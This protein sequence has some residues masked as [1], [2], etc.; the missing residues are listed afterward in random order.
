MT[1][2]AII[3][4]FRLFRFELSFSAGACVFLG[5][6][7]ALGHLP[8]LRGALYGFMSFF[9]ISATALILNDYFDVEI[10]RINAP[11]RPIPA[12][13]VTRS[14]VLILSIVVALLGFVS[15]Y[16]ISEEAFVVVFVVWLVG[17]LYNWRLK[18]AGLWGNLVVSFSV[19]M[20]FVFGGIAAGNPFEK[21]V[22]YL[23]MTAMLIDLGEEIAA[24]A[25]D[26]EGDR[27]GGSRSLAVVRG[28]QNAMRFAA[29]VFTLVV[30]G[31]AVPFLFGWFSRVYLL[32]IALLDTV[33]VYSVPKLLSPQIADRRKYVRLIYLGGLAVIVMFIV[34]RLWMA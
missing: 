24:D 19:G 10:D 6:L 25:L 1:R 12:G 20:T 8:S 32:P 33:I 26:V 3:G 11:S 28:P 17:L 23:A 34:I 16:V 9:F 5:E 13:L 29:G 27:L 21:T 30:A 7:L 22:W 14:Q 4:L 31:S 2:A 18:R 15:S